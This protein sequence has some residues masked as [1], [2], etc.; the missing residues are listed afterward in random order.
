M[1][2]Q[3]LRLRTYFP[4]TIITKRL[5]TYSATLAIANF[6]KIIPQG[7]YGF[8]SRFNTV[9]LR[10]QFGFGMTD[11]LVNNLAGQY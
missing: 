2:S 4:I 8:S 7:A 5:H 11:T 3:S 10:D 9:T 1:D 6:C